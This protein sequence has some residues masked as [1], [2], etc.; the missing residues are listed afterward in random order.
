MKFKFIT[1]FR[2]L[3]HCLLYPL[4]TVIK[5]NTQ[6]FCLHPDSLPGQLRTDVRVFTQTLNISSNVIPTP[7]M[8]SPHVPQ[9]AR[10]QQW[11]RSPQGYRGDPLA[12]LST[13][14]ARRRRRRPRR[15]THSL[16][17]S[18]TTATGTLSTTPQTP[19]TDIEDSDDGHQC[20]LYASQSSALL[21]STRRQ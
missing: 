5:I 21:N 9:R 3:H 11:R 15:Q 18:S 13:V 17:L 4:Y 1:V 10:P 16:R 6:V 20:V 7:S 8:S 2:K 12:I 19:N 14:L